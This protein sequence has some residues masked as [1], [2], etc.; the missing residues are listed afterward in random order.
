MQKCPKCGSKEIKKEDYMG[1][2][3]IK[4]PNC[5]YDEASQYD[6]YPEEKT[7][8]KAKESFTPYKSGGGKRTKK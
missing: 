1:V 3:C 2:S 5:G 8:Q 6:V 7:S 4:C